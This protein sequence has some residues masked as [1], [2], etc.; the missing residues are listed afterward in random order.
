MPS[1]SFQLTQVAAG[2]SF[3]PLN[4]PV[5]IALSL[6]SIIQTSLDG[7][8]RH[9]PKVPPFMNMG[10][11]DHII[12]LIVCEDEVSEYPYLYVVLFVLIFFYT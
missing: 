3:L 10:L 2:K 9:E 1:P 11:I 4:H 8:V 7:V 12:E 6:F 5:L